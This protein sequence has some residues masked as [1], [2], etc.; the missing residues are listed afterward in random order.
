MK[1][2]YLIILLQLAM[3]LSAQERIIN[4]NIEEYE[5][6]NNFAQ[7]RTFN[8][9]AAII[10]STVSIENFTIPD[11][12]K[13]QKNTILEISEA[14]FFSSTYLNSQEENSP[15][16]ILVSSPS[17]TPSEYC[18]VIFDRN[19]NS[20]FLDEKPRKIR[21]NE[22]NYIRLEVSEY[23]QLG[24]SFTVKDKGLFT[25]YVFWNH[26]YFAFRQ[27]I[28][29][30]LL[31]LNLMPTFLGLYFNIETTD[32]ADNTNKMQSFRDN[33]PFMFNGELYQL[34]DFDKNKK[35]IKIKKLKQQEKPY[36]YRLG[37]Y[38]NRAELERL[39]NLKMEDYAL[40]YFWGS[41]CQPCVANLDK[42]VQL[43]QLTDGREN[44]SMH[45]FSVAFSD[46][47]VAKTTE[48]TINH[49][50]SEQQ[51]IQRMP[52]PICEQKAQYFTDCNILDLLYVN[53]Y[54]TYLLLD[55]NGKIL[56]RGDNKDDEL[57]KLIAALE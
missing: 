53:T 56:Y 25:Q 35:T 31:S 39:A 45:Y 29:G 1:T 16:Y 22:A 7:N 5:F 34:Y 19:K 12:L 26:T 18:T 57:F 40:L 54:P 46:K 55:K 43:Q 3:N 2:F 44:W 27:M 8:V 50:L 47:Q 21:Y 51:N 49:G 48:L 15:I 33:E 38:T 4:L 24:L 30:A 11:K 41:W 17:D 20:S 37:Y 13:D 10:E 36:G 9:P 28:D 14:S 32:L 23:L 6:P 52:P 42:T